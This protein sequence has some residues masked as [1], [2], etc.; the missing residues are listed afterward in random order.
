MSKYTKGY[1]K[2]GNRVWLFDEN[3]R[4]YVKGGHSPVYSK[5]FYQAV[6]EG[7]TSRSWVVNGQ[8][9]A[10]NN[11]MGLY[12]DAQKEGKMWANVE[13]YKIVDKVNRCSTEILKKIFEIF[14][15]AEG[16]K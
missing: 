15:K 8:K 3:R 12:T 10:K 4:V 7:E 9:F 5:H 6:I 1:W 14:A 2:V 11:P 16:E 13:R